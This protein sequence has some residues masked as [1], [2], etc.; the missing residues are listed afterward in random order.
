MKAKKSLGQHFLTSR[1][2]VKKIVEAAAIQDSESVLEVGPGTGILTRALLE[3]G[4]HV[5][6]IEKDRH[7]IPILEDV[8]SKELRE[9]SLV[10]KEGDVLTHPLPN[11]PYKLIAN[12]PYYITG[13]ILERFLSAPL[14][15]S[16]AVLLVQKEVAERI[17][18]HDK[19]ESI[20][21]ISVKAFSAPKKIAVIKAGSFTPPPKVDSAI[22]VLESISK[23]R[24][25]YTDERSFFDLVKSG[26]AHKRKKLARNLERV[27]SKEIIERS[28]TKLSIP[29]S[30]RAEDVSLETW[31]DLAKEIYS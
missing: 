27:A 25:V 18:A 2:A 30:I 15:P 31:F 29:S 28:F 13:A 10:L 5:V 3:S 12:I 4:A 11:K 7:L 24:F 21:S 16:H 6:A 8:F 9:G 23:K 14:P 19:K 22:L 1:K 20:L 17:I 26:F